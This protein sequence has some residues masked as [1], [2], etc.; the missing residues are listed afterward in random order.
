DLAASGGFCIIGIY[1]ICTDF[2]KGKSRILRLSMPSFIKTET[3][4]TIW[5]LVLFSGIHVCTIKFLSGPP[6]YI[7]GGIPVLILIVLYA[8]LLFSN[9]KTFSVFIVFSGIVILLAAFWLAPF[10]FYYFGIPGLAPIMYNVSKIQGKGMLTGLI[11]FTGVI[12]ISL[13]FPRYSSIITSTIL[14]LCAVTAFVIS[15]K[16]NL[17]AADT[18]EVSSSGL[19]QIIIRI[20]KNMCVAVSL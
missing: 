2:P 20:Q 16:K 18:S 19:Q 17:P 5:W 3:A 10:P 8:I 15:F 9:R 12:L 6:D 1:R 13:L 4:Y 11:L 14:L 7:F